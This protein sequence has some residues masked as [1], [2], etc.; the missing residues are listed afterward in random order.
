[1]NKPTNSPENEKKKHSA[2]SWS[3]RPARGMKSL[4]VV[5]TKRIQKTSID[6]RITPLPW[7]RLLP[8]YSSMGTKSCSAFV[9]QNPP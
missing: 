4:L 2:H 6:T 8:I 5:L 7:I 1:M 3:L 9:A